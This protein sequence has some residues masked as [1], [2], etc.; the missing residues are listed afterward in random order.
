MYRLATLYHLFAGLGLRRG[1]GLGLLWRD[2]DWDAA[3]IQVTQQVLLLKGKT[4]IS[5]PKNATS[6]RTLPLSLYLVERLREHWRNQQE[7]RRLL[8]PRWKE[9]G[10]IFASVVG[11]RVTPRSLGRQFAAAVERGGLSDV[12]L[13]TLRHTCATLLGELGTQERVIEAILG[14]ALAT[15]TTHYAKTTMPR[16]AL[17]WSVWQVNYSAKQPSLRKL[18]PYLLP[19]P[20]RKPCVRTTQGFVVWRPRRDSNAQPFAP[21][22]NAL[23]IELRGLGILMK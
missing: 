4:V 5:T 6:V 7:E 15:V 14:H 16:C 20:K 10:L 23:S 2:L 3:T 21:E 9:H 13:H 1:E 19:C 8:G 12:H 17:H 22:A 11:T 18:L